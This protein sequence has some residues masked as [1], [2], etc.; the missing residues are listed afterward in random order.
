MLF[1]L[2]NEEHVKHAAQ[3]FQKGSRT[4]TA[5]VWLHTFHFK[6][7]AWVKEVEINHLN[8]QVK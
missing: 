1:I 7:L 8:I 6:L 4:V 3:T 5:Y 2:S